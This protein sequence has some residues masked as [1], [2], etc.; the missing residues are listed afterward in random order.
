MVMISNP[1][2]AYQFDNAV[3]LVGNVIEGASQEMEKFGPKDSP[4]W[5]PK[6]TM[7]QLL[8]DD[9]RLPTPKKP[10]TEQDAIAQL[11]SLA[12]RGLGVKVFKA[13]PNGDSE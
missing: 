6:Y 2:I 11:R 8:D 4:E 1:W 3:A 12:Q 9:F 10:P 5:K 13:K 7:A